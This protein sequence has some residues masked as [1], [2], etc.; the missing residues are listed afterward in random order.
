M[1]K[2]SLSA[3]ML[4][5]TLVL[6]ACGTVGAASMAPAAEFSDVKPEHWA[7]SSIQRAAGSGVVSG[8]PDGR[9]NPDVTI[10]RAEFLKMVI[11][12]AKIKVEGRSGGAT[13]YDPYVKAAAGDMIYKTTDFTGWTKPISRLEMAKLVVRAVDPSLKSAGDKQ[14]MYEAT[15][16]GLITGLSD[17]SIGKEKS[18]T[19]ATAAVVIDRML[20]LLDGKTLKVDKRAASYAEVDYRGTNLETMW[21]G[22]MN[23]LPQTHDLS[24]AVRGTFHQILIIDMDDKDGAYRE[25]V[26]SLIK[27]NGK[28][29]RGDYLVAYKIE[30]EALKTVPKTQVF[31]NRTVGNPYFRDAVI[32]NQDTTETPLSTRKGLLLNK[33]NKV[34]TWHLQTISKVELSEFQ[35]ANFRFWYFDWSGRG[36]FELS[37]DGRLFGNKENSK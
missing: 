3:A 28:D 25:W 34:I 20:T 1:K 32:L 27:V 11:L 31:F 10:S 23:P 22:H 7:A 2:G 13:W 14:L 29:W 26:P 9:F 35:Q 24:Y 33:Q 6:S 8:L 36:Y 30:M 15:K 12:A 16:K 18:S 4:C 37:K 19:R 17:G 21:G 5:F